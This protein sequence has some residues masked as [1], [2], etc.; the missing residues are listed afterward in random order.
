MPAGHGQG[1]NMKQQYNNSVNNSV[2]NH[3][4]SSNYYDNSSRYQDGNP[5]SSNNQ[6][7]KS[8][9]DYHPSGYQN[10]SPEQLEQLQL[11]KQHQ[12][13]LQEQIQTEDS[14]RMQQ[15]RVARPT[16]AMVVQDHPT[17]ESK[18]ANYY[19]YP[20]QPNTPFPD[21]EH[22]LPL[23]ERLVKLVKFPCSI[24]GKSLLLV[25][26]IEALLVI[27]MQIIIVVKYFQA[28]RDTP[29]HYEP[30][31]HVFQPYLD[32]GNKSR[33]I[34]A[35]L[36][37]FA[38]AQLFQIVMAWDAVRAQNTIQVIAFVVF[39]LCCFAYSIFEIS[40]T[41][42]ALQSSADFLESAWST[43][44][45]MTSLRPLLIIVVIVIGVTQ[46]I[47]TWLAYQLF[48]EFGWK[49]YK[50]IGADPNMKKM[51][52]AY[53]IYLVLIK[54]DLFFFVGFS[55]QFI[56]LTL[57]GRADPEYWLTIAVTPLTPLI[58]YV[59]FY[60]VRHESRRWM[61]TFILA[62]LCG[63]AYFAFKVLRMY[64]GLQRTKYEGVKKFLTLFAALCLLT[65]LLTIAN[66]AVC[67]RNFGKGLKPHILKENR[68]TLDST[69][70]T[71]ARVLE[72]D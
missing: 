17:Y 65:I 7:P 40:Q 30:N 25:F 16:A 2:N 50:K 63:V 36:I 33:S 28:L 12:Q 47:I 66:A 68:D 34:V 18:P 19:A 59:A 42:D 64:F 38:F 31:A 44:D 55:I 10:P 51:H 72:I 20:P 39:N 4:L 46:C 56:Y 67:Y 69:L 3:P 21:E 27:V 6:G 60:A 11:Q 32:P 23:K 24:Y 14:V 29:L 37:V 62:M 53:Q 5:Y 41:E 15:H 9:V 48:K 13:R 58:L 35:Y 57:D 70:P 45:L 43:T 52:R 61:S 54:V 71:G 22:R 26:S 49:I 1:T 8:E